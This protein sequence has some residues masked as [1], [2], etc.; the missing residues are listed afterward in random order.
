MTKVQAFGVFVEL[1]PG[2]EGMVHVSELS[3]GNVYDANTV[4]KVRAV[5]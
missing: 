4:A 3:S 2:R 1:G 5:S